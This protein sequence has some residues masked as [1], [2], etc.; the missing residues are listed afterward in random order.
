MTAEPAGGVI[1]VL[2]VHQGE[3]GQPADGTLKAQLRAQPVEQQGTEVGP[4]GTGHK[5]EDQLQG[6]LFGEVAGQGKDHLAGDRR[7]HRF[8]EGKSTDAPLAHVL[9]GP[10]SNAHQAGQIVS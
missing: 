7:N 1:K 9:Y 5:D 4:E 6:T 3:P 10:G 8:G 2:P